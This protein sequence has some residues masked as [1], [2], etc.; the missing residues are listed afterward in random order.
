MNSALGGLAFWTIAQDNIDILDSADFQP[1]SGNWSVDLSG[2]QAG[3]IYQDV[4]TNPGD[5]YTLDFFLS[6]N[7]DGGPAVKTLNVDI[8]DQTTQTFTYNI[9]ANGNTNANMKYAEQTYSF[10]ASTT[11]T[12]I[13]FTSLNNDA[14]G[15]WLDDVSLVDTVPLTVEERCETFILNGPQ[16]YFCSADQSGFYQCVAEPYT[17]QSRFQF[18]AGGTSCNCYYGVDCSVAPSPG[19]CTF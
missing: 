18:C 19:V 7:P 3:S 5:T 6:G 1:H 11:T 17:S 2:T 8:S 14:Y 4:T 16:G 15:P 10:V 13:Q 9:V 12:R